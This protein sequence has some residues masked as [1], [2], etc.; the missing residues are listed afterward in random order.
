MD[1][2]DFSSWGVDYLKYADCNGLGLPQFTRFNAMAQALNKTGRPIFLSAAK[3]DLSELSQLGSQVS[4]SWRTS[5]KVL[6]DPW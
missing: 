5:A 3:G 4:N 2:S 6:D 1:A